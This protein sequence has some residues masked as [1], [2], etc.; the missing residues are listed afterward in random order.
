MLWQSHLIWY[1]MG[2]L[3]VAC[4][5]CA[6]FHASHQSSYSLLGHLG[7]LGLGQAMLLQQRIDLVRSPQVVVDLTSFGPSDCRKLNCQCV[8]VAK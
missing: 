7:I 4:S 6:R 3:Y 8:S 5:I 2:R 1:T